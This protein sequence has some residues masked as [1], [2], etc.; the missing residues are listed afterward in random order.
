M[1]PGQSSNRSRGK[2]QDNSC[3]KRSGSVK[4][5][6]VKKRQNASILRLANESI[7]K[8]ERITAEEAKQS[9]Q[10][11]DRDSSS[12]FASLKRRASQTNG[13]QKR[14]KRRATLVKE[15]GKTDSEGE[16]TA[17]SIPRHSAPDSL[18]KYDEGI[19][20]PMKK[21]ALPKKNYKSQRGEVLDTSDQQIA[22]VEQAL[23]D[24]IYK[25]QKEF[26]KSIIQRDQEELIFQAHMKSLKQIGEADTRFGNLSTSIYTS[27]TTYLTSKQKKQDRKIETLQEATKL[28]KTK[29]QKAKA[30][31]TD[32]EQEVEELKR[33]NKQIEVD[34]IKEDLL[35][36]KF[37]DMTDSIQEVLT[38]LE[39][40]QDFPATG[41]PIKNRKGSQVNEKSPALELEDLSAEPTPRSKAKEV[42][43][44]KLEENPKAF[45]LR[46]FHLMIKE[47]I[48]SKGKIE[49]VTEETNYSK[50][51]ESKLSYL[52]YMMH[53]RGYPVN[54]IY[55]ERLKRIPTTQF[56][57]TLPQL[58]QEEAAAQ[59]QEQKNVEQDNDLPVDEDGKPIPPSDISFCSQSE[60]PSLFEGPMPQPTRP[61]LVN[62]L[63]LEVIPDYV[64]SSDEDDDESYTSSTRPWELKDDSKIHEP[65]H[66]RSE[67]DDLSRIQSHP[68]QD[69]SLEA[70]P[71]GDRAMRAIDSMDLSLEEV[72]SRGLLENSR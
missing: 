70:S 53:Q 35:S 1:G 17:V 37:E 58:E 43:A 25:I 38:Y 5:K 46:S 71:V 69:A 62:Q 8:I 47:I 32:L 19:C 39:K 31:I 66:K 23:R 67:I 30:R 34:M 57:E 45:I 26:S 20:I 49:Q 29:E 48:E 60:V 16:T 9:R 3:S 42:M 24:Q 50:Q 27:I 22:S 61:D 52:C 10:F 4:K 18:K 72:H 51:K 2:E 13:S 33:K 11:K 63:K 41:S 12:S 40:I 14:K 65:S 44:D 7:H 54:E 28:V 21:P 59:Q 68:D 15:T 64:T 55:E 56:M 36:N 6:G